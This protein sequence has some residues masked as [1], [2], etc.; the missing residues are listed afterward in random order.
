MARLLPLP[1]KGIAEPWPTG[2]PRGAHGE[3][4]GS[5]HGHPSRES[6]DSRGASAA[7]AATEVDVWNPSF[8]VTPQ[9]LITGG[10]VTE[11]GVFAP[12]EVCRELAER[13]E[14]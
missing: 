7:A 5:H 8:D 11:C 4:T 2:S 1:R 13:G 9:E 12:S 14:P 3:P 6:R 10:I